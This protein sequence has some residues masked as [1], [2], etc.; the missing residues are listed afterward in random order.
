MLRVI[1]QAS[2]AGPATDTLLQDN[3]LTD[4]RFLMVPVPVK[5]MRVWGE[6]GELLAMDTDPVEVPSAVGTNFTF[7]ESV[8][9]APSVMGRL[10]FSEKEK[11]FPLRSSFEISTGPAL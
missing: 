3:E 5:L 6:V 4:A 9:P 7:N 11:K 10:L 2:V 1:V 8:L